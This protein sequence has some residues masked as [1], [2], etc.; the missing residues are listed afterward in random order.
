[1]I[2]RLANAYDAYMTRI[3]NNDKFYPV[4]N[5]AACHDLELTMLYDEYLTLTNPNEPD[6]K[7]DFLARQ[8]IHAASTYVSSYAPSFWGD[9]AYYDYIPCSV[10]LMSCLTNAMSADDDNL[11]YDILTYLFT[12]AQPTDASRYAILRD[13]LPTHA[14]L[15]NWANEH[16]LILETNENLEPDNAIFDFTDLYHLTAR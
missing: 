15:W 2:D 16:D 4:E 7:L 9:D 8:L 1:M 11:L 6:T 3:H 5:L 13:A 12:G 14:P 10:D